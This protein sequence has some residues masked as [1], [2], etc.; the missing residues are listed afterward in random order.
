MFAA[1]IT[2]RDPAEILLKNTADREFP[3]VLLN[4]TPW[5]KCPIQVPKQ[6]DVCGRPSSARRPS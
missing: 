6:A 5:E 1:N 4:P 3:Q 2:N